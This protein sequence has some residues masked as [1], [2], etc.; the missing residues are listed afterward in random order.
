MLANSKPWN[1]DL[2]QSSIIT[3]INTTSCHH[4]QWIDQRTA[5]KVSRTIEQDNKS[6]LV[7]KSKV[8]TL[9]SKKRQNSSNQRLTT[10][11]PNGKQ[12]P[13]EEERFTLSIERKG[14][15]GKGDRAREEPRTALGF[16]PP[17]FVVGYDLLPLRFKS[18]GQHVGASGPSD[19]GSP[20]VA[21]WSPRF[22]GHAMFSYPKLQLTNR[23]RTV[24]D[25][26]RQ[27]SEN[28]CVSTT[29]RRH[30]SRRGIEMSRN[31]TTEE[32]TR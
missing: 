18:R 25:K 19:G 27:L 10:S 3:I 23:T 1:Q 30:V 13:E 31:T 8:A 6:Y 20:A 5:N 17:L 14:R 11:N 21:S 29:L 9:R 12:Q 24:I 15:A 26:L 32:L 28:K 2:Y 16:G 22:P 4:K 7:T